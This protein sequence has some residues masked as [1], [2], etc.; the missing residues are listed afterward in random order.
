MGKAKDVP[1]NAHHLLQG[2]PEYGTMQI[3]SIRLS[4]EVRRDARKQ[5]CMMSLFGIF[6]TFFMIR[7]SNWMPC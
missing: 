7:T 5:R 6:D 4:D 3:Y 2:G 1:M